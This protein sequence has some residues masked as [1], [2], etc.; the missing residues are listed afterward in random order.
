MRSVRFARFAPF[1]VA[2]V[3]AS[4]AALAIF[5]RGPEAEAGATHTVFVNNNAFCATPGAACAQPNSIEIAPG[6]TVR[7]VDGLI[8]GLH[9]VSQCTG[10]GTGCPAA[11]GFESGFLSDPPSGYLSQQFPSEGT[12]Y[13][14]CQVHGTPM[15]GIITV[16]NAATPTVTPSPSPS[17]TAS[18]SPSP[19]ASPSPS[20][21]PTPTASPMPTPAPQTASPSP[22]PSSRSDVNCDGATNGDDVLALLLHAAG[23]GAPAGPAGNGGCAPIGSA[24]GSIKGDLNCDGLADARDALVALYG[25]ADLPVPGL[26]E[27]CPGP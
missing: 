24:N 8:G 21:T 26:P 17:P 16:A 4:T 25:W 20:A 9:T 2:A 7:W 18:P 23:T 11:G 27:G 19:T 10:D 1:A 22:S 6:S 5:A 15:R 3:V 13:Y 12:F 14:Y